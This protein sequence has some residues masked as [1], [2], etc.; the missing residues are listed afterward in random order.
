M[1]KSKYTKE[2]LEPIV[3]ASYSLSEVLR[4][5]GLVQSG[6]NHRGIKGHIVCS[7]ISMDHFTGQAW[8]RGKTHINNSSVASSRAKNTYTDSE[9]FVKNSIYRGTLLKGRLLRLG[10]KERCFICGISEWLESKLTFHV[11]HINGESTDNR[12]ENLR[13]LCPN[14]HQQTETW[15]NKG[16]KMKQRISY[17]LPSKLCKDCDK[18]IRRTSVR[19]R[20]CEVIRRRSPMARGVTLR[21]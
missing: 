16:S 9:V 18:K 14:C 21:P 19:C 20:K 7:N 8:S 12:L 2:L 10:W 3:G 5:L 6:G 15:G 11:D 17:K 1:R 4:K 13:F